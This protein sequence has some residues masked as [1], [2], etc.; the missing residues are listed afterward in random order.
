M[1]KN[2]NRYTSTLVWSILGL[3][4]GIGPALLWGF[5]L[6]AFILDGSFEISVIVFSSFFL[7]IGVLFTVLGIKGLSS[8]LVVAFCNRI[9]EQDPDGIIEMDSV[10]AK[11]GAKKGSSYER[12]VIRAVEKDYFNKLTY[13]RTYRVF[14]LS[15]RV[16]NMEEYKNRF[17]GKNCPNC[18][19]PLK[20]KKGFSV[21]CDKCG[22][23][24][25]A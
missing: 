8:I 25:K 22:K 15:D 23:E 2:N 17:I 14:E 21:I 9:F 5:F 20:I 4:F 3:V 19:A 24:V 11:K 12:R 13:D 18:G 1:Y 16:N 7:A 6:L 10:L